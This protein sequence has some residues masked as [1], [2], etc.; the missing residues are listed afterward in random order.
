M[1]DTEGRL[2]AL[3]RRLSEHIVHYSTAIRDLNLKFDEERMARELMRAEFREQI[4]G[5]RETLQTWC[6]RVEGDLSKINRTIA[7]ELP[8]IRTLMKKIDSQLTVLSNGRHV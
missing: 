6:G 5:L 1:A 3:E 7:A 4:G 8:D 2:T